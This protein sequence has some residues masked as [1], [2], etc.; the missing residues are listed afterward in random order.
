MAEP[1][2]PKLPT[3]RTQVHAEFLVAFPPLPTNG[4]SINS[5]LVLSHVAVLDVETGRLT[6]WLCERKNPVKS[7]ER[8]QTHLSTRKP[9]QLWNKGEPVGGPGLSNR[10]Q[11]IILPDHGAVHQK[12][13]S[14]Q[15]S[16]TQRG[17]SILDLSYTPA[18]MCCRDFRARFITLAG[19]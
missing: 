13:R 5:V 18:K 7:R 1:Q 15:G 4:I 12:D 9:R 14:V 16:R 19:F 8:G 10:E 11:I 17:H 2:V 3:K 6:L